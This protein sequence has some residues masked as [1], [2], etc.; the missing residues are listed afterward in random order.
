MEGILFPIAILLIYGFLIYYGF[1]SFR[2]NP[3]KTTRL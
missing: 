3:F 2:R 1:I